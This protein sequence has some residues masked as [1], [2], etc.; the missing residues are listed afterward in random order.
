[1]MITPRAARLTAASLA[2]T[3]A[4]A[5]AAL[6]AAPASAT[7]TVQQHED[8]WYAVNRN[9][10]TWAQCAWDGRGYVDRG[11]ARDWQC[12][13]NGPWHPTQTYTLSILG[14]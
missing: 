10:F 8:Y 12:E 13:L 14:G 4:F 7:P 3:A 5:V 9:Y 1:M 6:V 11:E 2:A